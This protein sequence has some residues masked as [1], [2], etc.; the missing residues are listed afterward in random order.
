MVD[1][2]Q[3]G[4]DGRTRPHLLRGSSGMSSSS[5]RR[6]SAR[7]VV[8]CRTALALE[9]DLVAVLVGDRPAISSSMRWL[10]EASTFHCMR[11]AMS[12]FGRTM[13]HEFGQVLD[14]DR[15]AAACEP[16]FSAGS[17]VS[18]AAWMMT[19]PSTSTGGRGSIF[20]VFS[21][22]SGVPVAGAAAAASTGASVFLDGLVSG[23]SPLARACASRAREIAASSACRSAAALASLCCAA[24]L[25]LA[26]RRACVLT[27]TCLAPDGCE[28]MLRFNVWTSSLSRRDRVDLA[29]RS[30]ARAKRST[31]PLVVCNSWASSNI[32][33]KFHPL[34]HT[35]PAWA[36]PWHARHPKFCG[37][38]PRRVR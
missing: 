4:D 37:R 5:S 34:A 36:S 8:R 32:L 1:V 20:R 24:R 15:A 12:L 23:A 29:S 21:G 27:G 3:E 33:M 9:L 16:V 22:T 31:S 18:T 14:G 35:R 13:A 10:M 11:S 7:G 2:A 19:L 25:R 17:R 38:P 6:I 30:S 26:A 28:A